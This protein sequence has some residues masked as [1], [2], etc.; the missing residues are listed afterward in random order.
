MAGM[1]E[2]FIDAQA[3]YRFRLSAPDGTVIAV[4]KGFDDK[5]AAVTGIREVR[6]Y[7]GMGLIT[8]LCPGEPPASGAPSDGAA[9][10]IAGAA[11]SPFRSG[12]GDRSLPV[13]APGSARGVRSMT[14]T[15]PDTRAL[16]YRDLLEGSPDALLMIDSAG[17]IRFFNS[18][19]ETLFGHRRGWLLG[20]HYRTLLPGRFQEHHE[21]LREVFASDPRMRQVGT[22]LELFG[23]R[24]DGTEFP[25]EVNLAPATASVTNIVA[26]IRDVSERKRSDA[27]LREAL[28]LVSATLE[29]TADGILV[30]TADGK[31]AGSN[32][33]FATMWDIP[34]DLLASHDDGKVMGFV[35]DQ[36]TDPEAFV[37]KVQDLYADP[38]AESL[39]LLQ[40]RDGRTFERYSRPQRVADTIVGRVWS[41][42]DIT[43]RTRAQ[44]QARTALAELARQTEELKLLAFRD[45][46]TGLANR[47]L[48]RD[49]LEHALASRDRSGIHVLLLD[50]DDFKEV[51]DVLGHQAGDEMLIETGRR[52]L[53]CVAEE[54]TVAR[55]GGDEFVILLTSTP[56][57]GT[58]ASRIVAALNEPFTLHGRELRPGVSLGLI[59]ADE[60]LHAPDLMRRADIAMYAAKAAGKNRCLRFHPDMM[61]ALLAR[62]DMESGLRTAVEHGEISVHYQ[63]VVDTASATVTQV[64]ALVRWE[65]PDRTVLPSDFIPVSEAS[66]LI[67]AIGQ[68]VLTQTCAQLRP[69]LREDGNRAVAVNVSA[70]QLRE[71]GYARTVLDTL[72]NA[73][74]KGNQLILEVTE[75]VFLDPAPHIT[76]QLVL[77]R[78]HGI[79]V[80][81]DD[82]G[83]GYSSLGRL[84]N[85]P[86]DILKIDRSFVAVIH[87]GEEDLP[88]LDSMTA[89]AHHLGLHITA[90]G[91]ET[92]EQAQHLLRLGVDSLQGYLF[93]RPVPAQELPAAIH[94]AT[95]PIEALHHRNQQDPAHSTHQSDA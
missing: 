11:V 76:A 64:E 24:R 74:I 34:A 48:F 62:N 94:H 37:T 12:S 46:L 7:A 56:D 93:S 57:P 47:A 32:E 89:M 69:W 40:F 13:G 21:G 29:S 87:T 84:Q 8:D 36:L 66:G 4:S 31:I 26:T 23:L 35:L 61:T 1:F 52:L 41:F 82:F 5:A 9:P 65:R 27:A 63:P 79:R 10:V 25:M 50:L 33:R 16:S 18:A 71:P 72:A 95:E 60:T 38:G 6:A 20:R 81:L 91:V 73:G 44:D 43:A 68:E 42:R 51:N 45:H 88:I 14:E 49:R 22:D 58:V 3:R 19:A 39:D 59:S 15:L 80:A 86:V 54:D 90:E 28:S 30:V 77:L 67:N 2:L 85:L 92:P 53:H 78:S 75:S 55:L 17:A 83:T 70:V